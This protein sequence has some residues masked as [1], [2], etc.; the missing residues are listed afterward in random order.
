VK[1]LPDPKAAVV[2]RVMAELEGKE[3]YRLFTQ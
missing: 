3:K 2:K 1:L